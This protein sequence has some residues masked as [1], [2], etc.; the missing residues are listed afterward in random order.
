[1]ETEAFTWIIG[2]VAGFAVGLVGIGGGTLVMPF[3]VLYLE[4]PVLIAIGTDLVF[5][6]F[7]KWIGA[8]KHAKQ[9]TVDWWTTRYLLEGSVPAGLVATALLYI[10]GH[11]EF[12]L[13]TAF[14][15]P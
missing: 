10:L 2:V 13:H 12:G 9:K 6:A 14:L 1:M 4:L 11:E 15:T 5:A 7:I 8:A 3:L